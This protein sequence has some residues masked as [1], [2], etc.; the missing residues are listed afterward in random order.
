MLVLNPSTLQLAAPCNVLLLD[1][2]DP[3]QGQMQ[4]RALIVRLV[5]VLSS[6]CRVRPVSQLLVSVRGDGMLEV[7][8][9]L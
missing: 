6:P 9:G 7:L 8:M 4:R 5:E 1:V 3:A 2:C